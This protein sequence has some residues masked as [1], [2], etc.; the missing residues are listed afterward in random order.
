[1][2]KYKVIYSNSGHEHTSNISFQLNNC[3]PPEKLQ[4]QNDERRREEE[5]IKQPQPLFIHIHTRLI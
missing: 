2:S 1:M 4:I 3:I 5:K